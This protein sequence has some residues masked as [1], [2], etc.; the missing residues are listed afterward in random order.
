ML[1]NHRIKKGR[2][3]VLWLSLAG[4]LVL[5]IGIIMGSIYIGKIS[6]SS[7]SYKVLNGYLDVGYPNTLEVMPGS[8]SWPPHVSA[9]VKI[10]ET[11]FF[12]TNDDWQVARDFYDQKIQKAGFSLND[13]YGCSRGE[14]ANA[15]F[16]STDIMPT[17]KPELHLTTPYTIAFA[18]ISANASD[19]E[20]TKS[21][22][23]ITIRQSLKPGTTLIAFASASLDNSDPYSPGTPIR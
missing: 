12:V 14:C 8:N 22:I 18:I 4:V 19:E 23:P 2:R 9:N 13:E 16:F 20:F 1:N 10:N 7:V 21:G 11:G 3:I 5:L 6:G 15:V 17:D